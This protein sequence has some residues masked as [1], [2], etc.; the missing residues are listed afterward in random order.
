M[1]FPNSFT[2]AVDGVTTVAAALLNAIETIIGVN[3]ST[4]SNS[5]QYK[6]NHLLD[7]RTGVINAFGGTTPPTGALLCDGSAV[8]RTTYA[9]LFA[10]IGTTYGVGNGTTTFN[11]PDL[12]QR[13]PLGK[14]VSGTGA[15]LGGTGGALTHTHA[16]AETQALTVTAGTAA[17][18][19]DAYF[20][21]VTGVSLSTGNG[22]PTGS[23]N[24]ISPFQAVNYIIWY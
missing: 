4:D 12:R 16:F 8:S 3:N 14:A 7:T 17:A 9:A 5:L 20:T 2:A 18:P 15:T 22:G 21:V 11:V 24:N 10:I 1:S 6:I 23:S 13:F 19:G